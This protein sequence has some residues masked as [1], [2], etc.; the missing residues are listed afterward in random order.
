MVCYLLIFTKA[1][2]PP[3]VF[4]LPLSQF[5]ISYFPLSPM[6]MKCTCNASKSTYILYGVT[7]YI[8]TLLPVKILFE[9]RP[10]Q[11]VLLYLPKY[12]H[13]SIC[14]LISPLQPTAPIK[15]PVPRVEKVDDERGLVSNVHRLMDA[16]ERI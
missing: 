2:I 10:M 12:R 1:N 13:Y 8:Q 7:L 16:N 4:Y 5:F 15:G 3:C 11:N 6:E 14:R 9:M